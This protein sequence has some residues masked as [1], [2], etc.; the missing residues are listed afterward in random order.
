MIQMKWAAS[1]IAAAGRDPGE[2]HHRA[3]P[4]RHRHLPRPVQLPRAGAGRGAGA[5]VRGAARAR[6]PPP[7]LAAGGGVGAAAAP[8]PPPAPAP[9][10]PAPAQPA[11][12]RRHSGR[13][14]ALARAPLQPQRA[15]AAATAMGTVDGGVICGGGLQG[16]VQ[17][18]GKMQ[19]TR[20][21]VLGLSKIFKGWEEDGKQSRGGMAAGKYLW[22]VWH[23][24]CW[25]FSDTDYFVKYTESM[26]SILLQIALVRSQ[27][28]MV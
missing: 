9:L 12:R 1:C 28:E 4:R 25:N 23:L 26:I 27:Q 15:P 3:R 8:L 11:L 7:G 14:P 13:G 20:L 5:C 21:L 6:V 24:H 16:E 19:D 18:Y 10:L 17:G 2:R 22:M